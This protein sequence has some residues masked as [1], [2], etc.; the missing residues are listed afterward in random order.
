MNAMPALVV[1]PH[2]HAGN[3]PCSC[4]KHSHNGRTLGT[5][6]GN[7]HTLSAIVDKT[8]EAVATS[9]SSSLETHACHLLTCNQAWDYSGMNA[10]RYFE[11]S[12]GT[13]VLCC[14]QHISSIPQQL[15]LHI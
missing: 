3:V 5:L 15:L 11:A 14:Q 10:S 7:G 9:S 4:P 2:A 1:L 6:V 13:N 12:L 8:H